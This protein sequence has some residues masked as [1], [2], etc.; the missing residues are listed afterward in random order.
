M[1]KILINTKSTIG[2]YNK[3]NQYKNCLSD[4]Y[5]DNP[6]HFHLPMIYAMLLF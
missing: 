2:G 3:T 5:M 6:V 1:L 4:I